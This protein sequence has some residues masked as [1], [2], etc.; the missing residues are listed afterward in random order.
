MTNEKEMSKKH[1]LAT[2]RALEA[3][4]VLRSEIDRLEHELQIGSRLNACGELQSAHR[5]IALTSAVGAL[6]A[7]LE[8]NLFAEYITNV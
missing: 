3:L 4:R 8:D 7:A 1:S 5:C 6:R 2:A